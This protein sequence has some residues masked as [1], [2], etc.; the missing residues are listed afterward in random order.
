MKRAIRF[1]RNEQE[2]EQALESLKQTSCPHCRKTG[3]LNRHDTV[4]GNDPAEVNKQTQRGRR[5]WCSNRG[6]RGGCGRT[7]LI[8]FVGILPRHSF[9]AALLEALLTGL[10][11]GRSISQIWRSKPFA[12]PI[13]SV[14]HILQ[15]LRRRLDALRTA[16]CTRCAPPASR[17]ADPLRQAAEHLRCAFPSTASA[18][19]AFQYAFQAPIMG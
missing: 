4:N 18:V 9:P 12:F 19:E 6:Q 5:A 13:D 8:V 11:D 16:L 7:V 10:C 14:Y 15:R 3:T 2:L 17:H 1:V